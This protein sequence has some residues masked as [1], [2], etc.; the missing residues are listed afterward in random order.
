MMTKTRGEARGEKKV[1]YHIELEAIKRFQK[2]HS[3]YLERPG[4]LANGGHFGLGAE[5]IC[6]VSCNMYYSI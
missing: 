3:W 6:Y 2:L 1:S 5:S 4:L